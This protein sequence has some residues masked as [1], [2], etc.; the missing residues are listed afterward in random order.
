M[1][2]LYSLGL[3]LAFAVSSPYWLLQM[4]RSGKYRAGLSQ[5][6]GRVPPRLLADRRPAIWLHA[7]SVGEVL[8][9]GTLVAG[10]RQK[11]PSRRVLISTTT[12]T[13][14]E[15]A[16]QR[17]GEDSVF[18]F[19]LDFAFAVRP[20][21]R[22]LQPEMVVM[23][24]TEFWPNFLRLAQGS[25]ARIAVANARISDRSFP[26]YRRVRTLMR[27]IL[28]VVDCF[29]TQTQDDARRLAEIGAEPARVSVAGNLKFDITPP[30]EAAVVS[31]LRIAIERGAG[32]PV[33]V[34]GS[35]VENEEPPLLAA[36][37]S[38]LQQFPAATL[39]LA[40]RHPERFDDV[41]AMLQQSGLPWWRRSQAIPDSLRGGVLLLD[42][43]G[44]LASVYALAKIAFVGG[45]LVPRGGHNILEP[46]W[47]GAAILVGPHTENFREIVSL[48]RK[49]DA[50]QVVDGQGLEAAL[51]GL[52]SDPQECAALG[53]RARQVVSAHSGATARTMA[54]LDRLLAAR[55]NP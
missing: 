52:V 7:V 32:G 11:Y 41:A 33:L 39:I 16:R 22:T 31:Q 4:A 38:M 13:G 8:A 29:L 34:F 17:F 50:V 54:A 48:F 25:G 23:M 47:F 20:W 44:E 15:L 49:A 30:K 45:S 42:S 5:R 1:Y 27:S 2:L 55:V 9:A 10:L 26:R 19:P 14:Q 35:T 24:E 40:P 36:F 53:A 51:L 37:R 28:G 12:R 43:M 3:A 21:L 18:Y 46:A 6:L